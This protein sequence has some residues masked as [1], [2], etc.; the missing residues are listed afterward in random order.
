MAVILS[1]SVLILAGM[2]CQFLPQSAPIA[3]GA[4]V[5]ANDHAATP[6][7]TEA[8]ADAN[9]KFAFELYSNLSGASGGGNIIFSPYSISAAFAMAYEGARGRTAEEMASVFHFPADNQT[10]WSSFADLYNL[11]NIDNGGYSL[12]T[13]NAVWPQ[14]G[15]PILKDYLDTVANYYRG[16]VS[17]VDF[18]G[19]TE[20]ARR[21]I[22]EW[23]AGQT[24]GKIKELFPAGTLNPGTVL[25]LT[26]AIYFK[27]DWSMKFDKSKTVQ[28]DFHVSA[29]KTVTGPM[30]S[31]DTKGQASLRYADTGRIQILEFPFQGGDASMLILLPNAENTTGLEGSLSPETIQAWKN[32]LRKEEMKVQ[33]PRFNIKCSYNLID[34]LS[35]MGMPSAFAGPDFSGINGAGG[36][37]IG[38]AVHQAYI[39]V[40][41]EGAEAAGATG[42]GAWRGVPTAFIADHP[43]IFLIQDKATGTILFM[44]KVLDPTK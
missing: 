8:L 6:A 33:L 11:L 12:H 14:K 2:A 21:T 37:F 18:A 3:T 16:K 22:N 32:A 19:A 23:V 43:F 15:Y 36:L 39:N 9:N 26:N 10:R 30:M 29:D 41:E 34:T 24:N 4:L 40:N 5:R 44:G 42:I 1:L 31:L 27:G 25:A 20:Q 38:T 17:A 7:A 13:A 28:K 35:N